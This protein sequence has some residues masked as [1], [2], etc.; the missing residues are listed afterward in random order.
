M[1]GFKLSKQLRMCCISLYML[2]NIDLQRWVNGA[3][4]KHFIHIL[5]DSWIW[6]KQKRKNIEIVYVCLFYIYGGHHH[7]WSVHFNFIHSY[8]TTQRQTIAKKK[9][10]LLLLPQAKDFNNKQIINTFRQKFSDYLFGLKTFCLQ[11]T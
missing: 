2:I 9:P 1:R 6:S 11:F 7:M 5:V 8:Q 10:S 3:Q 4:C